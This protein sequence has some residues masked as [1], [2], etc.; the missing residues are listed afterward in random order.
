MAARLRQVAESRDLSPVLNPKAVHEA[1]QLA[2]MLPGEDYLQVRFLLG[3][4]HWYR[5]RALPADEGRAD[6]TGAVQAFTVCFIAGIDDLPEPLLPLVADTAVSQARGMLQRVQTFPEPTRLY[7]TVD[8][9]LRIVRS[10]PAH[11]P[12]RAGRLS[13]LSVALQIRC[14]RGGAAADLDT[15]IVLGEEA[16][17]AAPAGH[18]Q[19]APSLT[20]LGIAL[21]ARFRRGGSVTDL[22]TAIDRLQEAVQ[23]TPTDHPHRARYL[24]N[25]GNALQARFQRGGSVTDLDTAIDRLQEAVQATP[26]SH[27][28]R[29]V[30]LSNLGIALRARFGRGGAV[31]DLDTGIECLRQAVDATPTDHPDRTG[32]LSDLGDALRARFERGGSVTDL[33]TAIDRLQEAVQ[34]TPTDHPHR[35]RYLSNLGIA[36]RARFGRDGTVADLDTAIEVG[37]EAVKATAVSHSD[38]PVTLSNLG[39]AL[40]VR[41]QRGG[42]VTDLDTAIDRLQEAVQATPTDHPHRPTYLSNLGNAL[43][44]RFGQGG[45]VTDLD[46]AID[47]LQEAVQAT[48]TDHPHRPTYLSNLGNALQARFGQGGTVTDLDTA[49]DRLQEAVQAT[50]TDHHD[51]ARY[52]SNLGNALRARFE[53]GG[54]VADLDTAIDRL[55][56]A[57]EATPTDHHDRA[58]YLSNLGNALRARFEWGG[59]VADLDTAIDRLQEAMEATPTDHHDRARYLSNLGI[60]LRARFGRSGAVADLDTAIDRLQEAMEATPTDHHDRAGMLANLGNALQVRYERGGTVADRDTAI[61]RLQEAVETTPTDHPHH[62]RYL[63]NLGNALQVRYERGGTVADRDTAI[64]RLQ[65]AVETT[66]TD[67]PHHARYLSNLGNALQDRYERGGTVTDRDEAISAWSRASEVES[68][69]A[70][71]R[72]R[73]G[74]R[75]AGLLAQ[76]GEAG[77]AADAAEAAARLL[78]QV[79]PRRLER[80]DQQHAVGGF[81]GLVGTAAA[82]ALAAPG[83]TATER[84]ERALGLL[85]A[86]RAVL[87]SQTLETRSDLTDLRTHQPE[88][89]RR[90]AQLRNRL[91]QPPD[92]VVPPEGSDAGDDPRL[93]QNHVV[94][95]RHRLAEEF[96]AT[97]AEIR[98][99]ADFASFALPPTIDELKAEAAHGPIVVFN[100][101]THRSDA[102]LLTADAVT[103]LALP[104]LTQAGVINQITTFRQAQQLALS[105]A[106]PSEREDGQ[107]MLRDVLE[108]LWDAAAGPVLNAL[109]H[110]GRPP[111]AEDDG[112]VW[113]QVWWAP[114][115]LLGLLPVHA[116]GYHTDP[117]HDLGRRT[118]MDRVVS[119]YTPTV[120]ALR[121]ARDQVLRQVADPSAA[122]RTLIVAMPTT[123]GLPGHGRL[124]FVDDEAAMLQ[125]RL[126]DPVVLREPDPTDGHPDPT[127]T[128]PTKVNVLTHLPKCAIAHF[129][130]HGASNPIDPS[131]SRMLLHDH[132][133]DPLTVGSL[134]PVTLDR[135]RLAFLSAC[136]TAAIDADDLLD[137]A[138]HLTSAFQLAGFPHVIGT[139]WEIDDQ[140]AV[141]IA[142]SFYDG[143]RTDSAAVDPDRA[144]LALHQAVRG[145][146]DG[147]DL[148]P[149]YDRTRAPLLWAAHLHAGA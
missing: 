113:P 73:A 27:S 106:D 20:N 22:D 62:A 105:G 55:Q 132:A 43:Q 35:A 49:I 131:K 112:E 93:R 72:V 23:A 67:H 84:A 98:S 16:V 66:P 110:G 45:S 99:L 15:A 103:S 147:H 109:G 128:T 7:A 138:I 6:L 145:V 53:W 12:Q 11:H 130:C 122:G 127:T 38:R 26:A 88:L 40:Q 2:E 31:A 25:L 116:A 143:L 136:R 85:E 92:Q 81:A 78:P 120:R 65:K 76:S 34:A 52:L 37:Q 90:F 114:G 142:D 50:P 9:W 123:P 51:R 68:A 115:G 82:L 118:V 13:D 108:W 137:E 10:T 146:R 75:A 39:I 119:S 24:S 102:L 83:G 96:T 59:A 3:W 140:I 44:A 80:S 149:G 126:P 104:D 135:A 29:P 48:P 91:D 121:Y 41:F 64:D 60:A 42:S 70:S 30:M 94:Q 107:A 28:D 144:A 129:A 89:A 117:A 56:E 111:A 133:D 46:T 71:I 63:S 57:M 33:D 14:E 139:L 54:A 58:R 97:L 5:Y 18:R 134:A 47:R 21:Q 79:A 86:G 4:F 141:R 148:P 77:R 69:A 17:K 100:I 125:A 95:D 124:R 101:S 61:D 8:L 1:R 19:H 32:L 87:L 36:L 74:L